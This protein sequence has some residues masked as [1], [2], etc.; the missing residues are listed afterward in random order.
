MKCNESFV[1]FFI[2]ISYVIKIVTYGYGHVLNGPI[3]MKWNNLGDLLIMSWNHEFKLSFVW[4]KKK[5]KHPNI[6][7]TIFVREFKIKFQRP[8][9]DPKLMLFNGLI[10]FLSLNVSLLVVT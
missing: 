4:L 8:N 1:F 7:W 6:K 3:K 2:F 10:F 5:K 9:I